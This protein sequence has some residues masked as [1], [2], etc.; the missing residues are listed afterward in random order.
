MLGCMSAR[1]PAR[2]PGK[3]KKKKK[4]ARPTQV[5]EGFHVV[6]EQLDAAYAVVYDA[7]PLLQLQA[8]IGAVGEQQRVV[9][10]LLDGL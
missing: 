4:E 6:L 2:G 3:K 1:L 5:E 10:V 7:L 8:R 9:G